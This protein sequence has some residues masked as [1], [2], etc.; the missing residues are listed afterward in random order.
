MSPLTNLVCL[1][2]LGFSHCDAVV[3]H[4]EL[5]VHLYGLIDGVLQI[6]KDEG[7]TY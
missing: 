5:L 1:R 6:V 3:P 2:Y 7:E 4:V